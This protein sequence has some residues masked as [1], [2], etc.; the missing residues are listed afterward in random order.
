MMAVSCLFFPKPY[1]AFLLADKRKKKAF[2]GAINV[3]NEGDEGH[4][5][6]H[7]P[8][9]PPIMPPIMPYQASIKPLSC[10]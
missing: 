1:D 5:P 8:I 10:P 3:V 7:A 4:S 2:E 9:V 6:H